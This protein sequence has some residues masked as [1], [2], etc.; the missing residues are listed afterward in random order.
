MKL[1]QGPAALVFCA[2]ALGA[3][4]TLAQK[5]I[6]LDIVVT[7]QEIEV[8]QLIDGCPATLVYNK[9]WSSLRYHNSCRRT[10]AA[11]LKTLAKLWQAVIA[12]SKTAVKADSLGLGRLVMTFPEMARAAA[13][14]ATAVKDWD[15][16]RGRLSPAGKTAYVDNNRFYASLLTKAGL[17]ARLAP[18]IKAGGYE[19]GSVSVEKVLVGMPAGTPF[20]DWLTGQGMGVSDKAPFDA[21][22][23]IELKPVK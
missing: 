16:R 22:T 23:W 3:M 12:Q 4:P 19:A 11:K 7:K 2:L 1:L 18:A 13:I 10:D 6:T 15:R 20:A 21:Q 9:R 8:S 17:P 14:R 5:S